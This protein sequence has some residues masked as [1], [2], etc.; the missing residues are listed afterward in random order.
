MFF[1]PLQSGIGWKSRATRKGMPK[2]LPILQFFGSLNFGKIMEKEIW[3]DIPNYEGL[4]Q[5]SNQGRVKSLA[6]IVVSPR[7]KSYLKKE[8]I[9]KLNK[10]RSGYIDVQLSKNGVI[11]HH[12]IHKLVALA[13]LPNPSRLPQI[14]HIN[15]NKE[16]NR[17]INL[18]WCT[19]EYNINY[20]TGIKRRAASFRKKHGTPVVQLTMD[21]DFVARY[22]SIKDAEIATGICGSNIRAYARHKAYR[23]KAGNYTP[24][25]SAGGYKWE[26]E[27]NY[28]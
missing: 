7:Q 17:A 26:Y 2:A 10:T 13:F 15:E 11:K 24:R 14:N 16:D 20:G 6:A 9:L 4:Y 22:E 12:R 5:V 25:L 18:E 1:V 23:N 3:K 27:K 8:R 19:C 21:G 28:N